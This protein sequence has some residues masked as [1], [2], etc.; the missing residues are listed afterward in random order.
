MDLS[1]YVFNLPIANKSS[2]STP[3]KFLHLQVDQTAHITAI[4]KRKLI[5]PEKDVT[6][7][8][9]YPTYNSVGVSDT[10][11]GLNQENHSIAT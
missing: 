5:T 6:I 10:S 4:L 1:H 8:Y 2:L 9:L 3:S 7:R 11:T